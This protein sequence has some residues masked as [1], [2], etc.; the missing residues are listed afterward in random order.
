VFWL[1][2][3]LTEVSCRPSSALV[4]AQL[5]PIA[6]QRLRP[7]ELSWTTWAPFTVT[8]VRSVSGSQR[9]SSIAIATARLALDGIRPLYVLQPAETASLKLATGSPSS[10]AP[11]VHAE[12]STANR[13]RRES[14][15]RFMGRL[16][17][18]F[19]VEDIVTRGDC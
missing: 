6:E 3:W 14:L 15:L 12:P 7:A 4:L 10:G 8:R 13:V 1:M 9:F 17:S 16:N 19:L 2:T 5:L 18:A 11:A